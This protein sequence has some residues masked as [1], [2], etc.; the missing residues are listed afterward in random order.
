MEAGT[1]EIVEE[2]LVDGL[3]H[4]ASI[5]ISF[6]V[7]SV[8][9]VQETQAGTF[10]LV[11]RP[12][13]RPYVKDYDAVEHPTLWPQ[14]FDVTNWGLVAAYQQGVRV[15]GAVLAFNSAGIDWLEGRSDLTVLWD[16]RVSPEVRRRRV[17]QALFAT[18]ES[19]AR[20]RACS[21]LKVET[22]NINVPAC[23]FYAAQG[24]ELR[25]VNRGAYVMLSE[26]IQLFWYKR[27]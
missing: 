6:T 17:G 20:A 19:W 11:E 9:E 3:T 15:A 1:L 7:E 18:A 13:P 26:E 22:Q 23:R 10:E 5:P 21:E 24:C 4:H 8:F 27:L 25:V 16:L 12:N 2:T 14:R